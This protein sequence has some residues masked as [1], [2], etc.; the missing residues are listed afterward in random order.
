MGMPRTRLPT[1]FQPGA[2][3]CILDTYRSGKM[4]L[5]MSIFRIVSCLTRLVKR[6]FGAY[7]TGPCIQSSGD[8]HVTEHI[9]RISRTQVRELH[10]AGQDRVSS[11]PAFF[12]HVPR[13][14]MLDVTECVELPHTHGSRRVDHRLKRFGGIALPP[15]VPGKDVPRHRPFG[16]L[17]RQSRSAKECGI[18]PRFDKVRA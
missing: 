12:E 7:S 8:E 2:T 16:R 14:L 9:A 11:K 15:R 4:W 10:V 5:K 3:S 17:K 18:G 6:G 1:S 13:R